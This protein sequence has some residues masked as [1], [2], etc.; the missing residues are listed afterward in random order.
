MHLTDEEAIERIMSSGFCDGEGVATAWLKR[1]RKEAD[2]DMRLR[3]N[4]KI[5]TMVRQGYKN[6]E[7]A[8]QVNLSPSTVAKVAAQAIKGENK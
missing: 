3:R 8:K 6:G 7:I 1:A 2:A 5:A 4:R